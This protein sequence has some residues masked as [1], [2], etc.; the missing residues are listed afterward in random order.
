MIA[1]GGLI[2]IL[3]LVAVVAV[4]ATSVGAARSAPQLE[5]QLG[6]WVSDGLVSAE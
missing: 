1:I 4:V 5:Q 6:R 2:L 3:I